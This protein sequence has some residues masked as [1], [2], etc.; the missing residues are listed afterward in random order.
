MQGTLVTTP[1]T[2]RGARGSA[3]SPPKWG[4]VTL[5]IDRLGLSYHL[6][7]QYD[8]AQ[9]DIVHRRI[10]VRENEHVAPKETVHRFSV[11]MAHS[12]FPP[13]VVTADSFVV[14]GNTRTE[15]K[16]V[17]GERF[18]PAYVLDIVYETASEHERNLLTILG[19]TLNA[20][21][22]LP[23]TAAERRKS[24]EA[25]IQED[26][27]SEQIARALGIAQG[28][29]TQIKREI[30]ARA[31]L[32]RVNA[33]VNGG[34]S[35]TCQ[36]ALG[37]G[38]VL[39]LNDD[40][41]REVA[42]LAHEAGLNH[43]EIREI[44]K[45]ARETGSDEKALEYL[46]EKRAE[47]QGRIVQHSLTGNGRPPVSA[48]LRIHLA[49]VLKFVDREASLVERNPDVIERHLALLDATIKVLTRVKELQTT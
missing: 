28:Q 35:K 13:I 11:Q 6:E 10:Q 34:L 17:R 26:W 22:G 2:G 27:R 19:S 48:I 5:E 18:H 29:I 41:Y 47:M 4:A 46:A 37:T 25:M 12:E 31:R 21:N 39:A 32:E 20:T 9:I 42:Q 8:L 36:R 40:P 43:N 33:A 24:V 49:Y 44:A 45:A 1:T 14:D 23:L 7:P 3:A 38:E 15:A 16:Q 30:D